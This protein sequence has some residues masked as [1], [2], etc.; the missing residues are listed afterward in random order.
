MK[1]TNKVYSWLYEC[2]KNWHNKL[3][4]EDDRLTQKSVCS[5]ED[6]DSSDIKGKEGLTIDNLYSQNKELSKEK[7]KGKGKSKE[8]KVNKRQKT[9]KG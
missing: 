9:P 7:G 6:R 5:I 2:T 3:K 4:R 8:Q 1:R